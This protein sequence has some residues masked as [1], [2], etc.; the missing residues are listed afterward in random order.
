[1]AE[2]TWD[3]IKELLLETANKKKKALKNT[4]E[5]VTLSAIVSSLV[6]VVGALMADA[7][8]RE[9]RYIKKYVA[10]HGAEKLEQFLN[11]RADELQKHS[12]A[13]FDAEKKKGR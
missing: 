12:I 7:R 1:M 9:H 11:A 8:R 13:L 10:K 5:P 3:T 2:W 4:D 6:I